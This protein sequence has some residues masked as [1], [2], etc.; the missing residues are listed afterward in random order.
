MYIYIH[1]HTY[2]YTY[3]HTVLQSL[4]LLHYQSRLRHHCCSVLLQQ[5]LLHE[6]HAHTCIHIHTRTHLHTYIHIH[7]HIY[8]Y[9]YICIYIYMYTHTYIYI[10]T[11]IHTVL[12][13][14]LLLHYRSRLRDHCCTALLQQILLHDCHGLRVGMYAAHMYVCIYVCMHI[15][16]YVCIYVCMYVC[17]YG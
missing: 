5:T 6:K 17:M 12:P 2:T 9:I 13:S 7:I 11:Y 10:H 15:C 16:M 1:T 3:I 4:L 8:V 14:L